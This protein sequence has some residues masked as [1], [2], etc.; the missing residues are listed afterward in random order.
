MVND[1]VKQQNLEETTNRNVVIVLFLESDDLVPFGNTLECQNVM[2]IL[3][4][5]GMHRELSVNN[6]KRLCS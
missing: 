1:F 2:S 3:E 4:N 6:S 5:F